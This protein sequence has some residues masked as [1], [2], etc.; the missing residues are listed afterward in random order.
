MY[1]RPNIRSPPMA[2]AARLESRAEEA[3]GLR[4]RLELTER[5]RSTLVDERRQASRELEEEH[6][7]RAEEGTAILEAELA[8]L[9]QARE[10]PV[11]S[12]PRETHT[13]PAAP[14]A[15]QAGV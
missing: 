12:G 11:S 15:P 2:M 7:G 5:A 1:R 9:R 4:V 13:P 3:A 14:V 8:E 6:R 10:F